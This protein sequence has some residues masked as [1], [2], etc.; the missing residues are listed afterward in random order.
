MNVT[1]SQVIQKKEYIWRGENMIK[2]MWQN[3]KKF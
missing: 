3:I 2:Q 1:Y